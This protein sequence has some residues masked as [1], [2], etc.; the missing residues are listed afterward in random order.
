MVKLTNEQLLHELKQHAESFLRNGLR[1]YS[2]YFPDDF[3]GKEGWRY[4][5]WSQRAFEIIDQLEKL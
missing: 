5:K 1:A 4:Y 2:G 3:Y